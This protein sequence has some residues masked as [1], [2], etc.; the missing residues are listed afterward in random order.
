MEAVYRSVLVPAFSI[1]RV[2]LRTG[3]N[4]YGCSVNST[5]LMNM[6]TA[7]AANFKSESHFS[8]LVAQV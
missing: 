1:P 8:Y 6:A 5:I 4:L 3:W 2:P 7:M